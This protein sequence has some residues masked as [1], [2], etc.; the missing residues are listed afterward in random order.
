MLKKS[1]NILWRSSAHL[2][3]A[4]LVLL[5]SLWL[6]LVLLAAS[7]S[8][9]RWLLEKVVQSQKLVRFD[10]VSGSLRDGVFLKN[11]RF[12][13][14]IFY[15]N[16]ETLDLKLTW[17]SLLRGEVF[18]DRLRG[19]KVSLV[20]IG[21]PNPKP[22]KLKYLNLPF[23][24]I[25]ADGELTH[26][27]IDK[28]GFIVPINR[29]G[30]QAEWLHTQLDIHA[31]TFEHPK[32]ST[33]LSGLLHFK[34]NY[35]LQT[36]GVLQANFWQQ[37]QL[38]SLKTTL[39]GDLSS[40]NVALVAAKSF[41]VA[42]QTTVNL[43]HPK[44]AYSGS[45]RWGNIQ[46]PWLTQQALSS[47]HGQVF[48]RGNKQGLALSIIT[49]LKGKF[50]PQGEYRAFAETD[51]HSLHFL[52]LE[53]RTVLGGLLRIEG[54]VSWQKKVAW[55]VIS[56][57]HNVVPA[58]QWPI[59]A[60]Y[61]PI[62]T[63]QLQ[64]KG[65]ATQT[66]SD[67]TLTAKWLNNEQ[68]QAHLKSKAWP[69]QFDQGQRLDFNWKNINRS[70][71]GIGLVQSESGQL[72][73]Q[74]KPQQYQLD[75]NTVT[76]T[77]KTPQGQW[78]IVGQ[79]AKQQFNFE[80]LDYQGLAGHLQAEG[81]L[82]W[83]Q[84]LVWHADVDLDGLQT[85]Y[86]LPNWP[87]R[88]TGNTKSSGIWRKNDHQLDFMQ[89]SLQGD[90]NALPLQ[91]SGDLH[92]ELQPTG[93]LPRFQAHQVS[94]DWGKNHLGIE[95]GLSQT[96]DVT[97][98]NQFNDL[99]T[100]DT[101]LKGQLSGVVVLQGAEKAPALT[102][103]L[104]GE[105]L[106]FQQMGASSLSVSGTLPELGEG[107][108]FLQVS[109]QKIHAM[110]R[111]LPEFG[112]VLEG[113]R[114]AHQIS[115][116][117]IAEPVTAEGVLQGGLDNQLNWQGEKQAGMVEVGD[118]LWQLTA[119]FAVSWQQLEKKITLAPHCWLAEQAQLCSRDITQAS[120]QSAHA[121]VELSQ[122]EISRLSA[123]FPE[124]L[125]WQGALQ[126]SVEF[127]WQVNQAPDLKLELITDNGAIGLS[128]DDDEPLTLPYHQ[129]R[130]AANTEVDHQ[131]K[132]R[133]DMQAP[134]MG[135]GYIEARI[136]PE[137]KPYTINGAMLLEKV[138]LAILKPFLPAM[139][140]LTGEMN[141]SGGLSG[142][143]TRP[144]FYG[145][146]SLLEGEAAAKNTP[147]NLTHT[148]INASIRGKEASIT[149]Q[150]NS[151]EGLAKLAGKIDWSGEEPSMK[152]KFDGEK[153]EFK[154]KPLFKAKISP[155]L[156]IL[157]KP[158]YVDIKGKANVEDAILRPQIL[159]DKA[160]PL[161]ADVQ[162]I[163]L[164][165]K[166]RLK[167]AKVMRQWDINADIDLLLADNVLFQGFGLNSKLTGN[168]RLQ[169]Q[170]QRGMQAIGEITLDKEAK[171]EAYGQN[172]Q[173]RRGGLL[174]AGSITQPA[175]DIEAIK[176]VDS[177]VVGVRVEG[178]ANAPTLTLFAD[179]A[180]TQDEMLGYLLLGR[181]LYQEG[182][183]NLGGAGND[184][185][186]LASAALSLGIKGGQG[187][188]GD[189]GNALGVKNV[190][191]DAEGS[192]DDTRFTVSGYL[193]PRLYLR[194]GVGVFTPVNKVTLRYKLNKSLYLEAVSSLESALD[195]FYNFKF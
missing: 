29:L 22:T 185:A 85:H 86:W 11:F 52:P 130:L 194:Y 15:L 83:L 183:L 78:Q 163:D 77:P 177:K 51:W 42:L 128:R 167:I 40:L 124:G 36:K 129:L 16:A 28:R 182:Q 112:L 32:F 8:G 5:F 170:K 178:R 79:G 142:P 95:G 53:A 62:L 169:E 133:F 67:L 34:G 155:D 44:L 173:I 60:P 187:I 91:A 55:D 88:L 70:W 144:D 157:V 48:V 35:P 132:F 71:Q 72:N 17:T 73:V 184:T 175:L 21:P 2:T 126:G 119:P 171:Y 161:S 172:L 14:K 24:L 152:L 54:D 59:A 107:A 192:G 116:Q 69:W 81:Q 121:N 57:W 122:L 193:S 114:A 168:I 189:I 4:V 23:R 140:H 174:F 145:E 148:N 89:T 43:L 12:T 179:T 98:D 131:I 97:V 102:L 1:A 25:L 135:Q 104:S 180:M 125:A 115:W 100:L 18:V 154:Q 6:T 80:R 143:I 46:S 153:L 134:N 181:P 64:S 31:L 75:I 50:F 138:N 150:L 164:N 27:W 105:Q 74:G 190:T 87:A 159:S 108:G 141:L 49:D 160:I 101:R 47:R 149:G 92:L 93:Q 195:L 186:L 118:F 99:A 19:D 176:E 33:Q 76:T 41:P 30:L 109:A 63:G 147:I 58:R 156:D 117:M 66:G 45:V 113:T 111:V 96:W 26:A 146:F 20:F 84:G 56:Q 110:N 158:Y 137:D 139:R 9:S 106:Q 3:V 127:N 162:V 165:A 191:L 90:L 166:D 123:V 82:S 103:N 136:Q 188:A 61:L 120:H 10:V 151:G 94:V 39:S 7:A 38:K 68:W 37:K 65:F 13:G